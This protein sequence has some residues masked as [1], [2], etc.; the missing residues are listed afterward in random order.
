MDAVQWKR[1]M[2]LSSGYLEKFWEFLSHM[3]YESVCLH[4]VV[5]VSKF[6]KIIWV[7]PVCCQVFCS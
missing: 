7:H 1:K 6:V 4:K 5:L 3:M 2:L